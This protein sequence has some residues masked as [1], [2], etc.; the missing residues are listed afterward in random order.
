MPNSLTL[1]LLISLIP[2]TACTSSNTDTDTAPLSSTF[3]VVDNPHTGK[4]GFGEFTRYV[5]MNGLSVYGEDDVSDE[6][7]L[8]VANIFAELLDND[9]DGQWDDQAVF[10]ELLAKAGRVM[11]I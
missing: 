1:T 5:D 8:Y 2:L 10:D 6:K 3:T 9:E 4:S 7:L 11:L